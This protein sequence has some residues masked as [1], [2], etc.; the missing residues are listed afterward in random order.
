MSWI[1]T[2]SC[3]LTGSDPVYGLTTGVPTTATTSDSEKH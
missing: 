3:G 2:T 1:L